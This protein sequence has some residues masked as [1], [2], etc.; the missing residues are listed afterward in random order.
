MASN[1]GPQCT[2][3]NGFKLNNNGTCPHCGQMGQFFTS[4]ASGKAFEKCVT[5]LKMAGSRR[6]P[7][8]QPPATYFAPTLPAPAPHIQPPVPAF[9]PQPTQPVA[10][11]LPNAEIFQLT[12]EIKGLHDAINHLTNS[13]HLLTSQQEKSLLF[14]TKVMDSMSGNND[15]SKSYQEMV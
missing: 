9:A 8:Y 11:S 4:Q 15:M 13:I 2:F 6:P 3:D 1:F 5:C 7:G 12:N 10:P 14:M